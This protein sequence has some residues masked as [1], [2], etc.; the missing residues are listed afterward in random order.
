MLESLSVFSLIFLTVRALDK[1][2]LTLYRSCRQNSYAEKKYALRSSPTENLSSKRVLK[3]QVMPSI[4]HDGTTLWHS[5]PK[6]ALKPQLVQGQGAYYCEC[7]RWH[8][9]NL[10]L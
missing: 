3:I 10:A 4:T 2:T 5:A 1:F 7:F 9:R 8:Q 6:L